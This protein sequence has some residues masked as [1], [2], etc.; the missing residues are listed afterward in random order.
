PDLPLSVFVA[1][2]VDAAW[3]EIGPY[4]LAN[5]IDYAAWNGGSTTTASLSTAATVEALR[6]EEGAYRIVTPDEARTMAAEGSL[7]LHPMCGGI[8]PEVA[9]PYLRRVATEVAPAL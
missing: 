2:D 3:D 7:N 4:L 1:D 6:A 8:P 9:W 5:A